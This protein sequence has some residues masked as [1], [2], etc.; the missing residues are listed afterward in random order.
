MLLYCH[1]CE[2]SKS[3]RASVR[4][5]CL[6]TARREELRRSRDRIAAVPEDTVLRMLSKLAPP[7]RF[8]ARQVEWLCV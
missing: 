2:R 1:C 5:V 3:M 6:E 7:E 4:I 8:E